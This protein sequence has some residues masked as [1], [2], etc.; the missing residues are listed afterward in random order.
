[1]L[2]KDKFLAELNK[3]VTWQDPFSIWQ[4]MAESLLLFTMTIIR[5][6]LNF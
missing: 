6:F 2:Q 4:R 3:E 1:M 5:K